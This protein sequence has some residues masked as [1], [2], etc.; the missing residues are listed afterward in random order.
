MTDWIMRG[1]MVSTART[2]RAVG[3]GAFAGDRIARSGSSARWRVRLSIDSQG[4]IV[5]PGFIDVI[6]HD[7]SHSCDPDMAA[8]ASQC[9]HRRAL[10]CGVSLAQMVLRRSP[11]AAPLSI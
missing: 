9:D 10:E 4:K 6:T 11:A 1:G 5:A 7:D 8:K 3:R 2:R